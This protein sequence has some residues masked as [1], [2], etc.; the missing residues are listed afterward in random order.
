MNKS[1]VKTRLEAE[2]TLRQLLSV[3]QEE[4]VNTDE[5]LNVLVNFK[6]IKLSKFKGSNCKYI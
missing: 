6:S 5:V 4:E 3:E 1:P 2:R